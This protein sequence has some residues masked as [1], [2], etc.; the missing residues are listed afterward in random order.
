MM[1][2]A[3]LK[4]TFEHDSEKGYYQTYNPDHSGEE[5]Y[6]LILGDVG[7][8]VASKYSQAKDKFVDSGID[9]VLGASNALQMGGMTHGHMMG[10]YYFLSND[11]NDKLRNKTA[12]A[13]VDEL[14]N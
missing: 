10:T 13:I 14:K 7:F 5:K 9:S 3:D 2:L 11:Y 6:I 4:A 8:F 12:S 1:I